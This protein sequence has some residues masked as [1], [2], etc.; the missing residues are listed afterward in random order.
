MSEINLTPIG[1]LPS[2]QTEID[3]LGVVVL[4]QEESANYLIA[5]YPEKGRPSIVATFDPAT[6]HLFVVNT[7]ADER[8]RRVLDDVCERVVPALAASLDS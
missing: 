3:G 8:E 4:H 7:D 6:D 2:A 1:T 5:L